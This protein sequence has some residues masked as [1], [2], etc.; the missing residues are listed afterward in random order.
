MVNIRNFFLKEGQERKVIKKRN[1]RSIFSQR[2]RNITSLSTSRDHI[3]VLHSFKKQVTNIICT[4][5]CIRNVDQMAN[6]NTKY[7]SY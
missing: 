6:Q 3:S 2:F 1:I 4:K 5:N 7:S